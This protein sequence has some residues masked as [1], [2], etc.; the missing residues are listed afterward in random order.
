MC[1]SLSKREFPFLQPNIKSQKERKKKQRDT[2]C[3]WILGAVWCLFFC[4][5]YCFRSHLSIF[6]FLLLLR[7]WFRKWVIFTSLMIWLG[8]VRE[9]IYVIILS[10][11]PCPTTNKLY[12]EESWLVLLSF[13]EM[14]NVSGAI[15]GQGN[16]AS[17]E[18]CKERVSGRM[19]DSPE[20]EPSVSPTP[21]RSRTCICFHSLRFSCL[22][23][24]TKGCSNA[25]THLMRWALGGFFKGTHQI[26]VSKIL[27]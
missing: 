10:M 17:S 19:R 13:A 24:H 8:S 18:Q 22:G 3:P 1:R 25:G 20:Q 23:E 9:L 14:G 21:F 7:F 26:S 6:F 15:G 2:N 11:Q 12:E 4:L 5:F 16:S 27:D